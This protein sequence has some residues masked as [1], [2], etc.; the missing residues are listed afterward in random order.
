MINHESDY[1]IV[2][3]FDKQKDDVRYLKDIPRKIL[4]KRITKKFTSS[5]LKTISQSSI[6]IPDIS[7][8]IVRN[9]LL[10]IGII[11]AFPKNRTVP[12]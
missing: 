8:I 11:V 12:N 3:N 9:S 7:E 10:N 6:I 1:K 4:F 5:Y 2:S